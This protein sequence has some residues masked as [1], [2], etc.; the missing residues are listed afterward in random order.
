[1]GLKKQVATT[2][3]P[4]GLDTPG[5]TRPIRDKPNKMAAVDTPIEVPVYVEYE[6]HFTEPQIGRGRGTGKLLSDMPKVPQLLGWSVNI[7]AFTF[8]EEVQVIIGHNV[9]EMEVWAGGKLVY[10]S[11]KRTKAGSQ[12]PRHTLPSFDPNWEP[13][14]KVIQAKATPVVEDDDPIFDDDEDDFVEE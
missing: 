13:K 3:K 11:T 8:G 4:V 9:H 1:V 10:S 5:S 7:E 14:P 2:S 12:I 6:R